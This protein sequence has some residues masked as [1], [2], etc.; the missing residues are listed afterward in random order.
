[1][2]VG[3]KDG[4]SLFCSVDGRVH[5]TEPEDSEDDVCLTIAHDVEEMFLSNSFSISVEGTDVV[6][7]AGFVWSLVYILDCNGRGK[8]FDRES[9]F[10]DKLPVNARDVGTR[11]Y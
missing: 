4:Q 6:N 10:P 1:M 11:V 7:H 5:D 3:F 2:V 9:V 8:F